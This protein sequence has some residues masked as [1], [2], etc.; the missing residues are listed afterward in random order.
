MKLKNVFL[1]IIALFIALSFSACRKDNTV[2]NGSENQPSNYDSVVPDNN[3]V[4]NSQSVTTTVSYDETTTYFTPET[5]TVSVSTTLAD[6]PS[7]WSVARIIEEYKNAASKSADSVT[8]K[9]AITLQD[10]SV[11]GGGGA[12]SGVFQFVKPIITKVLENNSTDTQGI[13]G[14]Y[15]NL[16]SADVSSAIA[17]TIGE[18]TVI[19]L[20]LKE[21]IDGAKG[22]ALSGTVGHAISV[23]G[24]ISVVTDQLKDLGLPMDI[25]DENTTV[26]YTNPTVK[27]VID[28]NGI[29]LN[30]TWSYVVDISLKNYKIGNS[31]VEN[32]SVILE[33]V[34]TVN[35]GFSK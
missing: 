1:L 34:I 15:K 2:N 21:Q 35:G 33:N 20:I 27:V 13:T 28:K 8:S 19:E 10:M 23:V 22:D 3:P 7:L 9:Q 32:T 11:N 4:L 12:F 30:G 29:I 26:T 6:D 14:G 5:T 25:S 31:A 18:N 16:S 24:D 17:Y